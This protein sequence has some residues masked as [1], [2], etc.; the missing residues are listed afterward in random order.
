MIYFLKYFL[1]I[2]FIFEFIFDNLYFYNQQYEF[3]LFIPIFTVLIIYN[4]VFKVNTQN[5]LDLDLL[6]KYIILFIKTPNFLLNYMINIFKKVYVFIIFFKYRN[7]L[8]FIKIIFK[9]CFSNSFL[10]WRPLFKKTSYFG[11]YRSN[12]SK[13]IK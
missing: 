12:R 5:R 3:N 8:N 7:L 1:F 6:S 13:W 11:Y 9:K 4:I 10:L 2:F